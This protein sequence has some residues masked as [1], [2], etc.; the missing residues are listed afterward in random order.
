MTTVTVN[1]L[2]DGHVG[3]I[4]ELAAG[5]DGRRAH[6]AVRE[7]FF[8]ADRERAA[9]ALSCRYCRGGLAGVAVGA[10]S[11]TR[12]TGGAQTQLVVLCTDAARV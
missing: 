4:K 8:G 6:F 5:A 10:V 7:W 9:G 12:S 2:L 1:E 3:L 11:P